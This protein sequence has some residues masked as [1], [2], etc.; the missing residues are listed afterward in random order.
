MTLLTTLLDFRRHRRTRFTGERRVG[1]GAGAHHRSGRRD[2]GREL[3]QVFAALRANDLIW[4]YVINGYLEGKSTPSVDLLFWNADDSNL[5]GPMFCWYLRNTYLENKLA[6]PV[7]PF[8]VA[9]RWTLRPS[10]FR[11]SCTP[12]VRITSSVAGGLMRAPGCSAARLPSRSRQRPHR[13]GES[14]R[15]RRTNAITGRRCPA[16]G[17][18]VA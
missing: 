14:T 16:G 10:R 8:N 18:G 12:R 4:P 13:R 11:Y 1:G 7:R 3:A 2:A 5:A 9:C 15:R 6:S 17:R